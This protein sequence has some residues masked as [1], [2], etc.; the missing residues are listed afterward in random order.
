MSKK[1]LQGKPAPVEDQGEYV[2]TIHTDGAA[3]PNPGPGG[4]GA[5]IQHGESQR[6]IHRGFRR[7]TNNR[8]ELMAVIGALE[9]LDRPG[10]ALVYSDSTYV[11]NGITKGW[12]RGWRRRGWRRKNGPVPNA[13]MWQ[14]LLDLTSERPVTVRWVRGHSGVP[15]NERA[16]QLAE[17]GMLA[18]PF[19]EDTGF[20]G[21]VAQH[22]NEVT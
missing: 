16:D 12:A 10:S 21:R 5:V 14:R 1:D 6:E 18:G 22:G 4:Y 13:D 9:S 17:I 20:T 15:M 2:Y 19:S 8:M 3:R 11:V 7:T